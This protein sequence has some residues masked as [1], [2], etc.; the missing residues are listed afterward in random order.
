M[1]KVR[2]MVGMILLILFVFAG[3]S[4]AQ[5]AP[6]PMINTDE[7]KVGTWVKIRETVEGKSMDMWFGVVG[8]EKIDGVKYVWVEVRTTQGGQKIIVKSLMRMSSKEGV[9]DIKKIIVKMGNQPAM[10]ISPNMMSMMGQGINPFNTPSSQ[11]EEKSNAEIKTI[12][13]E[14]VSV[15]A[16]TFNA[17]H[18][19]VIEKDGS[20]VI[21]DMWETKKVPIGIVK[22]KSSDGAE[23]VL[24]A[25][26]S[27][28]HTE[29]TETPKP[30]TMPNIMNSNKK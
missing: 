24:L 15:P 14:R 16:G 20:G 28:A 1:R 30:F 9:S 7:L 22:V 18:V 17:K 26:G 19:R 29:I 12:G 8:E 2:L 21:I 11:G 25:Y 4:Q 27:G 10:E 13:N 3:I 6:F 5:I 23:M